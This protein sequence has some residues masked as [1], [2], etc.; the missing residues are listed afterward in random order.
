MMGEHKNWRVVHG[1]IAPPAFPT[2]VDPWAADRT[3]H[4]AT[5]D[6]GADALKSTS[7]HVVVQA[8]FATLLTGHPAMSVGCKL[9][10]KYRET[11]H[12]YWIV[13]ILVGTGAVA[14]KRD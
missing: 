5:H 8:R 14:I 9:P 2:F 6:P 4:V 7:H 10:S 13:E 11:T 3:K 12:A 1:V